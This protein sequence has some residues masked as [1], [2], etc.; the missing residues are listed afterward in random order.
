[1]EVYLSSE[2]HFL[3]SALDMPRTPAPR[4]T[5]PAL[6]PV[7]TARQRALQEAKLK[8]AAKGTRRITD[9]IGPPGPPPSLPP[10]EDNASQ[11]DPTS[12]AAAAPPATVTD[13]LPSEPA[14]EDPAP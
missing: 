11:E 4:V 5:R 14:P 2:S 13:D 3:A 9:C 6:T 7:K 10:L 1:M 12:P 8:T